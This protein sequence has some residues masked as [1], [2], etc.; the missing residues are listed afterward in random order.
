MSGHNKWSQIKV[1]KGAEDA[2]R[3]KLFSMLVRQITIEAKRA[4]GN[5]EDPGLKGAMSR[6]QDA[7]M[8][9]DNI[10]RAITKATGSGAESF[11]NMTYEAF[12]PGGVAIVIEAITDN[13]NRT[14]P[15]IKHL[16]SKQGLALGGQGSAMWAFDRINGELQPKSTVAITEEDG[17]K[18]AE[19]LDQLEDHPD[20]KNVI[21]N[22]E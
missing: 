5:R 17:L 19:I 7:N 12:G 18:L 4:L 3:S 8:P 20:I 14:T 21:T 15:E 11:E 10:E 16:L 22:A 6:A 2:K 9:K 13:K 1:K